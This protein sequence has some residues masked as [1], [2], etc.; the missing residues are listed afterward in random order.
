MNGYTLREETLPFSAQKLFPFVEMAKLWMYPFTFR[1]KK[2][3]LIYVYIF[4]CPVLS[5]RIQL[6]QIFLK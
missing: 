1:L 3:Q 5:L 6:S 4:F 2:Y